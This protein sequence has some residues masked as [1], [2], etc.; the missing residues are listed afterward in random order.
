MGLVIVDMQIQ[1]G[2]TPEAIGG[3][4]SLVKRARQRGERIFVVS[5]FEHGEPVYALRCALRGY[6]RVTNVTKN[7][8]DGS[9]H[10]MKKFRE[11][12][13]RPRSLEFCGVYTS[14]CVRHTFIGMAGR[15]K[16]TPMSL[17]PQACGDPDLNH[18]TVVSRIKHD[19][20]GFNNASVLNLSE[21]N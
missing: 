16:H 21:L 4:V 10:I 18:R 8:C 2:G 19:C 11:I 7:A 3:V 15:L 5:F 6:N 13:Y 17:I 1:F 12:G 14:Q 20:M 9:P